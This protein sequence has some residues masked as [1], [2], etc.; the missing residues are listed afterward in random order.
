MK[1]LLV[2]FVAVFALGIARAPAATATDHVLSCG[3]W[4]HIVS[5]GTAHSE[6]CVV[7]ETNDLLQVKATARFRLTGATTGGFRV[8]VDYVRLIRNGVVVS[9]CGGC[10]STFN[11]TGIYQV[12]ST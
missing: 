8:E 7:V 6:G 1:R 2:A 12:R 5:N 3:T 4:N 10:P 9:S 11:L